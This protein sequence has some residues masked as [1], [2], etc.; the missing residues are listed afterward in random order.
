[1]YSLDRGFGRPHNR[2]IRNR[3][4]LKCDGTRVETRFRLSAK[5]TSPFKSSGASVQ[6][7]AGSRGAQIS[8]SNAGY[9]KF[10]R[11]VKRTGY[12]LHSTVSPSLPHHCFTV[13]HHISTVLYV[14]EQESLAS[15]GNIRSM[16]QHDIAYAVPAPRSATG[17]WHR[18]ARNRLLPAGSLTVAATWAA[19]LQY[20]ALR[21]VT[22]DAEPAGRK[23]EG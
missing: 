7:T 16:P 8:G 22:K 13:C 10:H 21:W 3:L 5:R 14:F 11:S 19:E 15:V 1:M 20:N 12:P 2:S 17:F 18:I 9:T 23:Q 4:R 6:L